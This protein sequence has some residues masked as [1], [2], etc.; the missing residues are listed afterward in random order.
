MNLQIG[1][2]PVCSGS[3]NETKNCDEGLSEQVH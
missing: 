1:F 3:H 2:Q